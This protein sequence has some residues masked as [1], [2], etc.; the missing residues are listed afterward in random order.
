[1]SIRI[2]ESL[3]QAR[4]DYRHAVASAEAAR[5]HDDDTRATGVS[6][7]GLSR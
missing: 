2:F 1:M 6:R 7:A 3:R 4:E 5:W